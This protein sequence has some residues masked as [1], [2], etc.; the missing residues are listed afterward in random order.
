MAG[1][2]KFESEAK[3]LRQASIIGRRAEVAVGAISAS[4]A[5]AGPLKAGEQRDLLCKKC[6]AVLQNKLGTG[7]ASSAQ[8]QGAGHVEFPVP[9]FLEKALMTA[10]KLE[11][12]PA[13][14]SLAWLA[15]LAS[16]VH[17][18]VVCTGVHDEFKWIC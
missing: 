13:S 12:K 2:F 4:Q 5:L 3:M 10:A 9:T 11:T 6:V 18:H 16:G 8:E 7:S 1:K 15:A 17:H 14:E